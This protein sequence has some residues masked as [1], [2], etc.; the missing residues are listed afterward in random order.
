M[1]S[2]RILIADCTPSAMQEEFGRFGAQTNPRKLFETALRLHQPDLHAACVNIADGDALPQGTPLEA[3]DGNIILTG[4]AHFG[5]Y[6]DTPAVRSQIDFARAAFA[7]KRPDYGKAAGA[8]SSRQS[9]WVG[10]C[11]TMRR[12]GDLELPGAYAQRQPG[13]P[14]GC[15]TVGQRVLTPC[16]RTWMRLRRCR[17]AHPSSPRAASAKVQAMAAQTPEGGFFAGTQYHPEHVFATSAAF[18]R[19]AGEG[20]GCR[21]TGP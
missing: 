3:F 2:L 1:S 8:C 16:A 13:N 19:D 11:S 4:P 15:S 18:D 10:S 21:G 7:A 6:D 9:R 12:D 17:R 5:A 20:L 14:I